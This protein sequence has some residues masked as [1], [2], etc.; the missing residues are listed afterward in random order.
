MSVTPFLA[1]K[2]LKVHQRNAGTRGMLGKGIPDKGTQALIGR[3]ISDNTED[4]RPQ[5]IER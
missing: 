5:S 1:G 4:I 3:S 2:V